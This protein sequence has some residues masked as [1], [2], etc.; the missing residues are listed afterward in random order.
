MIPKMKKTRRA[1]LSSS[2]AGV[3]TK[4]PALG[5]PALYQ[6]HPNFQPD[7]RIGEI[8]RDLAAPLHATRIRDR[9]RRAITEREADLSGGYSLEIADPKA[10]RELEASLD[11]FR[12]FLS[13]SMDLRAAK[14]G[15]G[16][17]LES[18]LPKVCPLLPGRRSISTLPQTSQR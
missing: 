16:C 1:F 7:R 10:A 18:G 9:E 15:I 3:L 8:F 4:V 5:A 14:P 2:A 17:G 13:V 12:T 11:D 6:F